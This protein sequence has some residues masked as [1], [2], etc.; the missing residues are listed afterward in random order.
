MFLVKYLRATLEYMNAQ[1]STA[2]HNWVVLSLLGLTELTGIALLVRFL[3]TG[4]DIPEGPLTLL[5]YELMGLLASIGVVGGFHT[6]KAMK[7]ME[8]DSRL[9]GLT[10]PPVSPPPPEPKPEG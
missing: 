7:G 2:L 4:L 1:M 8:S 3:W 9:P 5:E 6:M 10:D